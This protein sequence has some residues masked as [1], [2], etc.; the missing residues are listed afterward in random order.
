MLWKSY[1]AIFIAFFHSIST[2]HG[3]FICYSYANS[4]V[5]SRSGYKMARWL[6]FLIADSIYHYCNFVLPLLQFCFAD[7]SFSHYC[8]VSYRLCR[9]PLCSPPLCSPPLCSLHLWSHLR[10]HLPPQCIGLLRCGWERRWNCW[11]TVWLHC[12]KHCISS[13]RGLAIERLFLPTS[14][15]VV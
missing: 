2:Y 4:L 11:G 1:D 7:S 8:N 15:S 5:V 10:H 9:L 14:M 3:N 12:Y 6:L 13:Y